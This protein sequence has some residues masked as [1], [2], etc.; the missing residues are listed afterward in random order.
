MVVLGE[1]CEGCDLLAVMP[2]HFSILF[3]HGPCSLHIIA[4]PPEMPQGGVMKDKIRDYE[5]KMH[6]M[7]LSYFSYYM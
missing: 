6:L 1:I 4:R 3:L 5:R 2:P 7:L